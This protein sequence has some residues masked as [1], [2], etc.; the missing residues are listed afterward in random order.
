M[1]LDRI[2]RFAALTGGQDLAILFLLEAPRNTTFVSAKDMHN[3]GAAT[4]VVEDGIGAYSKLQAVMMDNPDIPYIPTLLLSTVDGLAE[5][6]RKYTT[7]LNIPKQETKPTATSFELLRLCTA[8]P[9]MPHQTAFYLSDLFSSLRELAA[10]CTAVS[11]APKPSSPS[12]RG[13]GF[14]S[15]ITSTQGS[16]LGFN[17]TLSDD[18]AVT[19][20]KRLRDLIGDKECADIVDF[21][22]EEWVME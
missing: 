11:S 8:N 2:R 18:G 21:W 13:A 5:L 1:T 20:L 12:S 9:P 10:A 16:G 6:L 19:K 22:K 3:S 17:T 4:S 14:S 7:S 15:Q